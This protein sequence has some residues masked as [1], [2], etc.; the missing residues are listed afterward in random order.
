MFRRTSLAFKSKV[1][2]QNYVTDLDI[3]ITFVEAQNIKLRYQGHVRSIETIDAIGL[4]FKI[5]QVA[6]PGT[7]TSAVEQRV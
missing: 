5:R 6:N 7:E 1:C 3:K 2:S 4:C